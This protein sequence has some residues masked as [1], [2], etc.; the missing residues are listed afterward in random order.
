[1]SINIKVNIDVDKIVD[2]KISKTFK[3]YANTR[4][5]A[6]CDSYVPFRNGILSSNVSITPECITYK[7][8]YAAKMYTG[9]GFNFLHE[10]HR[11]ATSRWDKAM[12]IAKGDRF[13]KDLQNAIDKNENFMDAENRQT[14]SE[15]NRRYQEALR[16]IHGN[17]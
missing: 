8:P 9:D 15:I 7:V 4:L 11:E 1:M 5:W 2:K 13:K 16:K 17:K 10:H 6:F 3:L 12:M 14:L